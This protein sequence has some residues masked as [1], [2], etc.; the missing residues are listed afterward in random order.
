MKRSNLLNPS[1]RLEVLQFKLAYHQP[2]CCFW[3]SCCICCLHRC[4]DDYF[5]FTLPP[6]PQPPQPPKRFTSPC[7]WTPPSNFFL[8]NIS[9]NP[10]LLHTEKK[11]SLL[12]TAFLSHFSSSSSFSFSFSLFFS[13][14]LSFHC[15]FFFHIIVLD[16]LLSY[17]L[18]IVIISVK[19]IKHYLTTN[20]NNFL[21][22]SFCYF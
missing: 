10:S 13:F 19:L 6:Q 7:Y 4:H 18:F 21:W 9:S 22:L 3:C 14:F 2:S 15:E 11:N 12:Q 8:P 16:E 20:V 1:V 5:T 17:Y